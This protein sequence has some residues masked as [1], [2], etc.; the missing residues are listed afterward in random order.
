VDDDTQ[1]HT[2]I[3]KIESEIGHKFPPTA[4]I[5]T[6][7][8]HRT[9]LFRSTLILPRVVPLVKTPGGNVDFIA[10]PGMVLLPGSCTVAKYSWDKSPVEVGIAELPS[11]VAAMVRAKPET[12]NGG[13]KHRLGNSCV[14]RQSDLERLIGRCVPDQ[15][16]MRWHCLFK[17]ARGLRGL[18]EFCESSRD[19]LEPVLREWHRRSLR[20]I[21]TQDID[22]SRRDLWE[23]Y[24]RV[25]FPGGS[26]GRLAAMVDPN[27]G[28]APLEIRLDNLCAA[29]QAASGDGPF[30][31]ACRSAAEV[32]GAS[33]VTISRILRDMRAA[34]ILE[35][36]KAGHRR[37]ASEYRWIGGDE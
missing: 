15:F 35:L 5:K 21:R 27:I 28:N 22:I 16:G 14:S 25:K 33:Y 2:G 9:H 11:G 20:F 31:L 8:D 3:A 12:Q 24:R 32:L 34:K 17:L 37:R 6:G 36:V 1:D 18:P 13:M 30:F 29:L 19:D 26:C 23:G 4:I 10:H 7:R